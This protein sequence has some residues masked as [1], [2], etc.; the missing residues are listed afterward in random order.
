MGKALVG[1]RSDLHSVRLLD[2]IRSLRARVA[3]LEAALVRA[4]E[5]LAA[6]PVE[7]RRVD[8]DVVDPDVVDPDVVDP[9]VVDP[10][11]VELGPGGPGPEASDVDRPPASVAAGESTAP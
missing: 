1:G 8:P 6:G 9:D 10:D 3:E 7:P 4:E 2:E 11:V 5:A